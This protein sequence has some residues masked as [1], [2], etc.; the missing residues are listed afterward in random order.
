VIIVENSELS[1]QKVQTP[2]H[3]SFPLGFEI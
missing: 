3:S 2:E 1:F